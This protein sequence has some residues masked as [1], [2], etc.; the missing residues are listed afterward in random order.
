M[1]NKKAGNQLILMVVITIL[2]QGFLLI[3]N[4]LLASNFGVGV[5]IDAFNFVTNLSNFIFSFIGAGVGTVLIPFMREKKDR[6]SVNIFITAIYLLGIILAIAIFLFRG[7]IIQILGGNVGQD[8]V[9]IASN[10]LIFAIS[11][12]FFN[13]INTLITGILEFYNTYL[14]QKTTMLVL[15][16]LGVGYLFLHRSFSITEY[17]AILATIAILTTVVNA[18]FTRNID[19]KYRPNLDVKDQTFKEM[20]Q[21]MGPAVLS[22]G[23]YQL[24]V[25]IDTLI[26]A[27]LPEG[28]ISVLN[29]SNTIV[30]MFNMLILTN[31][32]TY[33]Y[34]K[35]IQKDSEQERQDSL[36]DYVLVVSVILC[37]FVVA[38]VLVGR[39]GI[40]ILY[41]RGEFS[42][43]DT[44]VVFLAS[45]LYLLQLPANGIRELMYKYFY[46]QRNTYF[47]FVNSIMV[48]LMNF[49]FS[50][51][52][53]Q[54]FGVYGVIAGTVL[55]GYF[56]LA[57][58]T[59]GFAKKYS[60]MVSGRMVMTE[61]GKIVLTSLLTVAIALIVKS[62]LPLMNV[63]VSVAFYGILTL[64][65]FLLL[66]KVFRSAI[67]K[68]R[69]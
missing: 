20:L 8:F 44:Q 68:V 50:I 62:L 59:R 15:T 29:Y 14:K 5:E 63:F 16:V 52:L 27:R 43:D 4:S 26:A 37:F 41:Q 60:V 33:F 51:I 25:L 46:A 54:F 12:A 7:Q 40:S 35:L 66:L 17:S 69:I 19:F 18:F 31:L 2:T 32:S 65:L 30:A 11:V 39:E 10:L 28:S 24:S 42:A 3:K 64:I 34:P 45:L 56:S 67:Y 21:L 57:N 55:A 48:S 53:V 47:P 61:L 22:T 1:N 13:S 49:I 36:V 38:F 6:R 58:I 9:R 23:V